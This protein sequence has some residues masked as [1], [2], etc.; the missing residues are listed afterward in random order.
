MNP[1]GGQIRLPNAD[2]VS[3]SQWD[4]CTAMPSSV[5]YLFLTAN[6]V[7]L[8]HY[9]ASNSMARVIANRLTVQNG[10]LFN[11][12][13]TTGECVYLYRVGQKNWTVLEVCDSRICMYCMSLYI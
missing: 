4:T 2:G 12:R 11:Q 5:N 3:H 10:L 1:D 9:F 7:L 6:V 13:Q 8:L